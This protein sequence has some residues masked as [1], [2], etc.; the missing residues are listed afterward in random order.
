MVEAFK[1]FVQCFC[2]LPVA[3]SICGTMLVIHGGVNPGGA[4]L[5]DV[6]ERLNRHREPEG[7]GMPFLADP[8]NDL[9]WADPSPELGYGDEEVQFNE[10]RQT[11]S[12]YG[13]NGT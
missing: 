11:G 3:V 1:A 8:L 7:G 6:L 2:H 10:Q 13:A 12:V 9:L 5:T 4:F